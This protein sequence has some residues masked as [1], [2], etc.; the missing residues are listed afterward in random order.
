MAIACRQNI[1]Q[2]HMDHFLKGLIFVE[3]KEG[4]RRLTLWAAPLSAEEKMRLKVQ[5]SQH[6]SVQTAWD[7]GVLLGS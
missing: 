6:I 4:V 7:T 3:K 2:R 1:T 5:L